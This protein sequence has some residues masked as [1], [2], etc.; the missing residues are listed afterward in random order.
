MLSEGAYAKIVRDQNGFI[1][2]LWNIPSANVRLDRNKETGERYI[3]VYSNDGKI[4]ERLE[5]GFM[6]A[7]SGGS[8]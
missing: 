3:D 6:N 4:S 7:G 1:K 2:E 5:G 8:R